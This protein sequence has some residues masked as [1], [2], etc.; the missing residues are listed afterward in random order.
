[1]NVMCL[2]GKLVVWQ[3]ILNTGDGM[4]IFVCTC[5]P[6]F[7]NCEKVQLIIDDEIT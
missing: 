2:L 4:I 5:Q 1:M 3:S 6:S 7:G